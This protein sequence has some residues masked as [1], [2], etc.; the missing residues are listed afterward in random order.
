[1]KYTEIFFENLIQITLAATTG[2]Q[3]KNWMKNDN[4]EKV[5]KNANKEIYNGDL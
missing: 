5:M 4:K 1:M 3:V 2:T